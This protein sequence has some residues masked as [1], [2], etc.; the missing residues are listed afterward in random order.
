MKPA[1]KAGW[2]ILITLLIVA[3][4]RNLYIAD[5]QQV[6]NFQT[7][8]DSLDA[9]KRGLDATAAGIN[10]TI[11]NSQT[12]FQA[13]M[14]KT[15]KLLESS[16]KNIDAVTGGNSFCYAIASFMTKDLVSFEIATH[17]DSPLH[18]V[19]VELIDVDKEEKLLSSQPFSME[20][21]S[22]FVFPQPNIPFL[23]SITMRALG[24]YPIV[25]V[26]RRKFAF[27]FFQYKRGVASKL[28]H[29]PC[30]WKMDAGNPC[31]KGNEWRK[32]N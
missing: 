13:T 14:D 20:L 15:E 11:A 28:K 30:E 23:S 24:E 22:Q 1:E 17:G 27:N 5:A 18:D 2:V 31:H 19:Q 6:T 26:D 3:E 7:I 32:E 10:A 8:S 16:K 29:S 9:T 21:R 12:Q 25:G 4:I